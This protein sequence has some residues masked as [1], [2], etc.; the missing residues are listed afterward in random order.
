ML[1]LSAFL[2][3]LLLG[4]LQPGH[5]EVVGSAPNGFSIRHSIVVPA[6][7]DIAWARF[8]QIQNWWSN[9][10]TYSGSTANMSLEL[11]VGGCWCERLADEGVVEHMRV[12][13]LRPGNALRLIGG[14]GPLSQLGAS[15]A[16]SVSL[17]PVDGANTRVDMIYV[18]S[19]Y[20]PGREGLGGLARPVD[21][22]LGAALVSFADDVRKAS[23]APSQAP[24]PPP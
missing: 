22:V 14:L 17:T 23:E 8:V 2:C 11:K 4:S 7:K 15:G 20:A 19:G 1:R 21:G 6:S 12:S 3:L 5:A 16:L 13:V 9:E 10:H 18:V 24:P